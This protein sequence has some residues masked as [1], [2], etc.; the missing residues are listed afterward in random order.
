MSVALGKRIDQLYDLRTKRLNLE[1]QAAT[2]KEREDVL[3]TAL[4]AMLQKSQLEKA[5]GS[6]ATLS[7][8]RIPIARIEDWAGVL[9]WAVKWEAPDVIQRRLNVTS[10][11]EHCAG[12]ATAS[13]ALQIEELLK[14]SLTKK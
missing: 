9:N 11:L 2:L 10:Y 4:L 8:H 3:S 13:D 1:R 6:L 7:V 5:S 12:G 14:V